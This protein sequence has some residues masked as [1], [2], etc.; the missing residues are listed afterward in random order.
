MADEKDKQPT[1]VGGQ[2]TGDTTESGNP[3]HKPDGKFD[4]KEGTGGSTTNEQNVPNT[5]I[6]NESATIDLTDSGDFAY[7]DDEDIDL[8]E[9]GDYDYLDD[10]NLDEI[11]SK[12]EASKIFDDITNNIFDETDL[13]EFYSGLS[14]E[15]KD[16]LL[17]NSSYG[18]DLEKLKN[19]S[20]EEKQ[21]ILAIE[22]ALAIK[23]N[24]LKQ[25]ADL[26]NKHFE[27][28]WKYESYVTADKYVD[29]EA[30]IQS[31]ID[32][33]EEMIE[34]SEDN[35]FQ[36]E[37]YQRKL[38]ET[39]KF[40]EAGKKYLELKAKYD[41]ISDLTKDFKDVLKKYQ[42]SNSAYSQQR[43]DAAIWISDGS[44]YAITEKAKKVFSDVSNKV[45]AQATPGEKEAIKKYT[46]SFS[47]IN[48]PLR[49]FEYSGSKGQYWGVH[50]KSFR[51][52]VENMTSIIDKSTYNEDIWVQ[53]GL[54]S[55]TRIFTLPNTNKKIGLDGLTEEEL[56]SLVGTKFKDN[57][58]YSSGAG[59]GTGFSHKNLI[60]N[61]YCPSGTKMLYVG[62][63][64][65]KSE[66]ADTTENE[67][68]LQRGYEYRIIKVEKSG[69]K[70]YVDVE[71]I[72]DSDE[73][74]PTGEQLDKI[75]EKYSS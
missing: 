8:S 63:D 26:N 49:E 33:Y 37:M 12:E 7:L 4:T 52:T 32:Y 23:Q 34:K 62:D 20:Y 28:A 57:G 54:P 51:Q 25:L 61:T 72:L 24:Y 41:K 64:E 15:E 38:E 35:S 58:F 66:Y 18:Y 27:S 43:K 40:Q 9:S 10:A 48:E 65:E 11:M 14:E 68:I 5:P 56:Q 73:G 45:F 3:N 17:E 13:T 36:K 39:F 2:P 71:V 29:K 53:R 30:T 67:M 6:E 19:A 46:G 59:K 74:K 1:T 60:L 55:S 70:Y 44:S 69:Y 21:A 50:N 31:K 16:E 75:W 42:D 22:K 47:R